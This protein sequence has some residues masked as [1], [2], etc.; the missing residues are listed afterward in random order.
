[1]NSLEEARP[2]SFYFK[3]DVAKLCRHSDYVE[4]YPLVLLRSILLSLLKA[5]LEVVVVVNIV[6]VVVIVAIVAV[7]M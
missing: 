4:K 6:M 7:Y 5:I 3:R 1:M 2:E